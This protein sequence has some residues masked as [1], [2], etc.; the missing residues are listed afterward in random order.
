MINIK[1]IITETLLVYESWKNAENQFNIS[2]KELRTL[3]H[4][5]PSN[6]QYFQSNTDETQAPNKFL[7]VLAKWYSKG[8]FRLNETHIKDLLSQYMYLQ[9]KNKLKPEDRNI[10]KFRKYSGFEQMM[11]RYFKAL[12]MITT[13]TEG[14]VNYSDNVKKIYDKNGW[15]VWATKTYPATKEFIKYLYDMGDEDLHGYGIEKYEKG[16]CPYCI[17]Q[18]IYW[19]DYAQGDPNYTIYW[20]LNNKNEPDI[21]RGEGH[22]K[23]VATTDSNADLLDEVD[24]SFIEDDLE[25]M[26]REFINIIGQIP[27]DSVSRANDWELPYIMGGYI[28][29]N[30]DKLKKMQ[31][32][33]TLYDLLSEYDKKHPENPILKEIIMGYINNAK[34]SLSRDELGNIVKYCEDFSDEEVI[35]KFEDWYKR[36]IK[37]HLDGSGESLTSPELIYLK[38]GCEK[39]FHCDE[40]FKKLIEKYI[41]KTISIELSDDSSIR[42]VLDKA[43]LFVDLIKKVNSNGGVNIILPFINSKLKALSDD[44]HLNT[45]IIEWAGDFL[46]KHNLRIKAMDDIFESQI[47][48]LEGSQD[49][50]ARMRYAMMKY[51]ENNPD[52]RILKKYVDKLVDGEIS[53]NS[54][55]MSYVIAFYVKSFNDTSPL[56]QLVDLYIKCDADEFDRNMRAETIKFVDENLDTTKYGK[57]YITKRLESLF[58]GEIDNLSYGENELLKNLMYNGVSGKIIDDYME[59]LSA[60]NYNNKGE[61][62]LLFAYENVEPEKA[63]KLETERRQRLGE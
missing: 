52:K 34:V 24:N 43:E 12:E 38:L 37:K 14:K 33:Y 10:N 56:D 58:K 27:Y 45:Q 62:A 50:T 11:E 29:N 44:R 5:D 30:R 8:Q 23:V 40:E 41:K 1:N 13:D 15:Q 25:N 26:P 53:C 2:E 7:P 42:D 17:M 16:Q 21:V 18:K 35:K 6:D 20:I 60:Q 22:D 55:A 31:L 39:I 46:A 57:K 32:N 28:E 47:D 63:K 54:H 51:F 49:L 3:A 4:K 61:Y 59:L 48:H 36:K 9:R 19:D